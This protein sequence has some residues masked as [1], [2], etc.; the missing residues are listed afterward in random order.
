[1]K[2]NNVLYIIIRKTISSI[3]IL[4]EVG[5]CRIRC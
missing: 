3:R 1:M 5:R 2:D 4:I